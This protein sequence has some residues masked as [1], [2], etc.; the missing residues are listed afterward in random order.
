[1]KKF[2]RKIWNILQLRLHDTMIK[3]KQNI[4]SKSLSKKYDI[5]LTYITSRGNWYYTSWK[6][7]LS[8]SGGLVTNIG[9]HFFDIL[10][11]IFGDVKTSKVNISNHES[12]AGYIELENARIRWF[13]SIIIKI[14]PMR[15]KIKVK[16]LLDLK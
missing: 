15:L 8:K 5:D 12:S 11:W 9:I 10:I 2:G 3:L 1:M 13:L 6:G 14:F 4:D 7:D 16:E